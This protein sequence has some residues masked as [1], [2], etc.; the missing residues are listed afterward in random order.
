MTWLYQPGRRLAQFCFNVFGRLEVT[1]REAVPPYGPLIVVANHLSY[2]DP[3]SLVASLPRVLDF[4]G[5]KE[6]FSSPFK[7]VVMQAVRVHSL[8]R[9]I[10]GINA[11]RTALDLLAQDR[12]V[13]VFPEGHIS[14][15][16]ALEEGL[17]GAAY[18]A[19]KSQAP[20]LP[21]GI[22]GTEKFAPWRM[23]FP[24]CRFRVNIGQPFTPPVIEGRLS[25][26]VVTSVVDMIMGRIAT[27]LPP[28]YQGIYAIP[29]LSEDPATPAT[30]PHS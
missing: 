24:L 3:P 23:P 8:D 6:L 25:R 13:V 2:N 14:A 10:G 19:I 1:G 30:P 18:L 11:M 21:V 20:I 17:P 26:E 12:A 15:E 7:R 28:D 27:L 16:F 5:K 29:G 22:W 9:E 4:L